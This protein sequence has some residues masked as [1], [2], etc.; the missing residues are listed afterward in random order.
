MLSEWEDLAKGDWTTRPYEW[1]GLHDDTMSGFMKFAYDLEWGI[2]GVARR[3]EAPRY[4][5]MFGD[6]RPVEPKKPPLR[7]YLLT[8]FDETEVDD[9][10]ARR[11]VREAEQAALAAWR[12]SWRGRVVL[13]SREARVRIGAAWDVLRHGVEIDR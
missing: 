4:I 1:G 12:K 9:Y 8:K 13:A 7:D 11:A 3:Y 6:E 10:F 2:D 5:E